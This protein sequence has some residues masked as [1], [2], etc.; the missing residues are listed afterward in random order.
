MSKDLAIDVVPAI[1]P[2][3][4]WIVTR[5]KKEGEILIKFAFEENRVAS[6][7]GRESDVKIGIY[8]V[9]AAGFM[10]LSRRRV[11]REPQVGRSF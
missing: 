9:A 2:E 11:L 1:V 3:S 6:S 5:K 10:E 8:A 4:A 7:A